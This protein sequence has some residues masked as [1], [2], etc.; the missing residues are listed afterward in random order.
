MEK[1]PPQDP[2]FKNFYHFRQLSIG[3]PRIKGPIV[4][5]HL[6]G[7]CRRELFKV[8]P[9][10]AALAAGLVL[11]ALT[12]CTPD[13]KRHDALTH[14][15][16][17]LQQRSTTAPNNAQAVK[18]GPSQCV[19]S[20]EIITVARSIRGDDQFARIHNALKFLIEGFAYDPQYNQRQFTRTAADLFRDRTLGGCSDYALAGLA[21][22][23]AM[24]FPALLV[25]TASREWIERYN[26]NRLSLVYG[27]SFIELFVD[28]RWYLA[29]PNHFVLYERYDPKD[30]D[31]P[32]KE[33]FI[34]RGYDFW[35]L[36]L[37]SS[38]DAEALLVR[39]ALTEPLPAFKAPALR[40]RFVVSFNLPELFVNLG[41]VLARKNNDF[42]ALKRYQ[43]A[44][45]LDPKFVP[46]YLNRAAL[47]LR[48]Q[49]YAEAV[50]DCDKALTLEPGNRQAHYYRG[51][52]RR[53]LG[54]SA[55]MQEDVR[56]ATE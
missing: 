1:V 15:W 52:A 54:N 35:D 37:H 27:H 21:L 30:R 40:E 45:E 47:L 12:A 28:G 33:V 46:A 20:D 41:D 9:C 6:R 23:R 34:K 3:N 16:Q 53:G 10:L 19:L 8:P 39:K 43:R 26:T 2:L 51:Q 11:L 7:W 42:L 48:L 13:A 32:R 18:A 4:I 49:R 24:D 22:F 50:Q 17:E 44:I 56:K 55:G 5:I 29:D 38:E 14:T 25:V 31:Y 36:G